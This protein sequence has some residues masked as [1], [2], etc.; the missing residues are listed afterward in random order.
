[1]FVSKVRA[2]ASDRSPYGDFWF[3]PISSRTSSGMRVSNDQAMRL[4]AVYAC[5]R[6][7]SETFATMPFVLYRN[8]PGGGKDI[9]KDHWLNRLFDKRPNEYQNPF[10]WREMLQGHLVLRGNAF[11]RIIANGRGEITDLVPIHPDRVRVQVLDDGNYRYLVKNQKGTDDILLRG[12]MWHIRGLSSDG[13]IGLN[14]IEMARESIGMAMSAQD[15]GSRF[16]ANDA[17]PTAGWIEMTGGFSTDDARKTFRASW[18]ALQ[19]GQNRGKVP[20]LENGMKYHEVGMTNKDSQ[21]IEARQFQKTDI[22]SIFRVPPHLIGD[23]S[24]STNNNIEQQSLEFEKF[25]MT[26]W[27][28]RWEASVEAELLFDDDDLEIEFDSTGLMRGDSKGRAEYYASGV[29]NGWLTRNEARAQENLDPIVGL[30]EPLMP[31]NMI[32]ADDVAEPS[33]PKQNIAPE[34]DPEA[35]PDARLVALAK[36]AAERVARKEAAAFASAL[37]LPVD[38]EL[39]D[40]ARAKH[41]EFVAQ[42][43]NVSADE[44]N[45]YMAARAS[46]PIRTAHQS[47]DIYEAAYKRLYSLALKGTP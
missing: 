18:Q 1:M 39:L 33:Q 20:V 47:E 26:P 9:I 28:E 22:A 32:E 16:F 5:V 35:E 13:L 36:A 23:L 44:A 19:T 41:S 45:N 3:Q 6:V 12:E 17:R 21:F 38:A 27:C 2:D 8:K 29:Q 34:P 30:D 46:D 37:K 11:N 25:T 4:T 10:E 42:V 15:Y 31:L 43:L 7:L 40:A 24:R 14:P